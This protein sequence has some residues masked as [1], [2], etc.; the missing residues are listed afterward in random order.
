MKKLVILHQHFCTPD[1]GGATR[2]YEIAKFLSNHFDVEVISLDKINKWKGKDYPYSE[3][4]DGF[5]VTWVKGTY[6]NNLSFYARIRIFLKFVVSSLAI[7]RRKKIDYLYSTSTPLTVGIPGLL[8][9]PF[10]NFKYIFE[11]RDQ[12]PSVPV[13]LGSI[14]NPILIN[15]LNTLE[16]TI[17]K[18]ADLIIALSPGMKKGIEKSISSRFKR[19][20]VVATN[21]C[22]REFF[23][24][25]KRKSEKARNSLNIDKDKFVIGYVGTLGY[26]NQAEYLVLLAESLQEHSDFQFLI[27]GDGQDSKK[28]KGLIADKS[29]NNITLIGRLPKNKMPDI[30][31]ACDASIST[32]RDVKI[33]EDNSA[34]KFFDTLASG[35][36]V[37]INH[38]GWQKDLIEKHN[39]G[40]SLSR[41]INEASEQIKKLVFSNGN[42]I[43]EMQKN[44]LQLSKAFDRKIINER[45]LASIKKID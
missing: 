4:R 29:L 45:I 6:N 11:V 3:I 32:I 5:K 35:K 12:W 37:L 28:I 31:S 23:Y 13:A 40:L 41:N 26:V 16:V 7:I 15:L 18:S 21:G 25:D 34:N 14:K 42:I 39:C 17:Y 27:V 38:G 44:S 30:F 36:V 2:V 20:I 1:M 8:L 19:E 10:K 9:K 22:D 33:L 24:S 43:R